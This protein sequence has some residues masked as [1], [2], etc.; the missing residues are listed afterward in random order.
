MTIT[1]PPISATNGMTQADRLNQSSVAGAER[2]LGPYL[3]ANEAKMVLS[4]SPLST[5]C[6][7]SFR[8][9]GAAGHLIISHPESS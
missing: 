9:D 6:F 1:A 4:S 7:S 2:T 3:A 8:M 5:Y